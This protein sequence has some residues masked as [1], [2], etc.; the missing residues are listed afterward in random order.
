MLYVLKSGIRYFV[1]FQKIRNLNKS[2]NKQND[3]GNK[4]EML[5][6]AVR[7]YSNNKTNIEIDEYND[8]SICGL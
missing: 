1:V 4:K 2:Q 8:N 3:L 7:N 5:N 6:F